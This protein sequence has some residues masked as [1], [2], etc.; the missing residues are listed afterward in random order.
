MGLLWLQ[1]RADQREHRFGLE[2]WLALAAAQLLGW[3]LDVW[4]NCPHQQTIA[5]ALLVLAFSLSWNHWPAQR[6]NLVLGG[7]LTGLLVVSPPTRVCEHLYP[8][9]EVWPATVVQAQRSYL[10]LYAYEETGDAPRDVLL[11]ARIG[12]LAMAGQLQL[13][14]GYSSLFPSQ[15]IRAWTF[16]TVG[17]LDINEKSR[18]NVGLGVM[19]GG[20][21]DKL[22]IDGILLSPQWRWL[23]PHLQQCGWV[24][25]GDEGQVQVWHRELKPRP[26]AE[27]LKQVLF[28]RLGR[29]T[30]AQSLVPN[31]PDVIR[32]DAN[33]GLRPFTEVSCSPARVTRN[34][35]QLEISANPGPQ[36]AMV[37]V[38]QPYVD[39]YR[40]FLQDRELSVH[41][42]NLQHLAVQIP[43]G[44][45]AGTLH[46]EY[47]P[48]ALKRGL[49]LALL[50][51]LAG[52]FLSA[53]AGKK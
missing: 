17:S 4:H 26:G 6:R 40:A 28:C 10:S 50:G 9:D 29:E 51:L 27:S 41:N 15:L 18:Q 33:P 31:G 49:L 1:R 32:D 52:A 11:P 14:N 44:S 5:P 35:I 47:R 16:H 23:A 53:W 3:G 8:F 19:P 38:R 37:A 45:P 12:N 13:V 43:A 24:H 7:V 30:A 2:V 25:A 39:G 46:L 34:Q 36:P 20:L 22:G 21:T 42:L 48:R